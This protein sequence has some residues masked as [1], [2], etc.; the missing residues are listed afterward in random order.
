MMIPFE[1]LTYPVQWVPVLD[2]K[3]ERLSLKIYPSPFEVFLSIFD[4]WNELT[5]FGYL[6][7]ILNEGGLTE[8]GLTK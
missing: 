3:K 2:G 1:P 5:E 8:G 4:R 7:L 6:Y